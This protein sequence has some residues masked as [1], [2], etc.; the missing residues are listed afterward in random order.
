MRMRKIKFR[1]G[2]TLMEALLASTL[3]S[4]GASAVL[5]PFNVGAQSEQ[6]DARRTTALYL[7]RELMEEIIVK[8]FDDPQ[9]D[10]GLGADSGES[11]R[12]LYDN[13]D[14]YHGY[15][16]GYGETID[17]MVGVDKQILDTLATEGL[18]RKV[19]IT[20][21]HV[22]GQDE[23][24]ASNFVSVKVKVKYQGNKILVLR[25]LVHNPSV[26]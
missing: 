15:Q 10:E 21:L 2:M 23:G 25:R 19:V 11:S 3:L 20:Y 5:L 18:K 24:E 7:A 9:G 16:D 8:P 12:A 1:R 4:M 26:Q 13:I 17:Q 22:S 14:D 6:E